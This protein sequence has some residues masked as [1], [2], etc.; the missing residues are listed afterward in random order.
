MVSAKAIIKIKCPCCKAVLTIDLEYVTEKRR[1]RRIVAY[2]KAA[3]N[4]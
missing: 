1:S 2:Q 3:H 4:T